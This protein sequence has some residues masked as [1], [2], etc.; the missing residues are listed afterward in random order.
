MNQVEALAALAVENWKLQATLGRSVTDL[1]EE[2]RA[3]VEAQL[4]YS[5]GQLERILAEADVSLITFDGEE[6]SAELPVS[7][8]NAEDFEGAEVTFVDQTLEPT[9]IAAGSV[10]R[11]GRVLLR[12]Q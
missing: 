8:V 6:F 10:I 2:K 7:P 11:V 12:G 4:R 9:V 5:R 1:A 3:R